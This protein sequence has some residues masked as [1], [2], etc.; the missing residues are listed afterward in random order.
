[1]MVEWHK[2]GNFYCVRCDVVYYPTGS[3]A[4]SFALARGRCSI[5]DGELVNPKEEIERLRK[6]IDDVKLSRTKELLGGEKQ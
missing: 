3:E 6:I 5:C 1:M 2:P 4:R